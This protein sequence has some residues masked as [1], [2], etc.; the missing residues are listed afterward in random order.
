MKLLY[1]LSATQ[2]SPE[3]KFHGGGAYGEVVF[4]KLIELI[5]EGFFSSENI[6]CYYNSKEYINPEILEE[7]KLHNIKLFDISTQTVKSMVKEGNI[8]RLYSAMLN[9]NQD[10]PLGEIETYTTVHGLRTLEMPFDSIM[11]NYA[12]GLKEKIKYHLFMGIAKKYY[13]KKLHIINGRL[14][15][16]KRIKVITISNHSLASI[17]SFYPKLKDEYIPAFASPTFNQLKKHKPQAV[18]EGDFSKLTEKYGIE[19]MK[20]FLITSAA[21]WTKNALRAVQAYD[22]LVTDKIGKNFKVVVTGVTNKKVFTK[23]LKNP[24]NFVFLDYVERDVLEAL[25]SNQYAFIYPS[26]NEGFGY[27]PVEAFKYGI[28]VAAS[29]T[30]SIPEVCGDAAIFFDPYSISEIKNRYVQLLDKNIYDE[31]SARA[32]KQFTKVSE[33]QSKDLQSLA[34]YILRT[35]I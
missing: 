24:Q 25:T 7:I 26:L 21:R 20:Y 1:D 4:F 12:K 10:L 5:D 15:T 9:L 17:K 2:P 22:S 34:E 23:N 27:P 6:A 32:V 30:T 28:P 29:G 33:K 19:K 8:T 18:K 31:Y 11:F 14:V 13:L 35:A 16:D 3:S